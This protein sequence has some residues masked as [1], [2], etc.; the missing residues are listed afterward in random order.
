MKRIAPKGPVRARSSVKLPRR[1]N[2]PEVR[3]ARSGL[4][5]RG[6]AAPPAP[7]APREVEPARLRWEC[8]PKKISAKTSHQTLKTDIGTVGQER[9]IKALKMGISIGGPGYNIFVCGHQGT[10]R[11]SAVK[12]I[13]RAARPAWSKLRDRCYV[14]N[15]KDHDRP[16]L[17]TLE[18]GKGKLLKSEMDEAILLLKK[19]IP[20]ELEKDQFASRKKD[21][22]ERYQDNERELYGGLEDKLRKT[23]FCLGQVQEGAITRQ[24]LFP[25][26]DGKPYG[27]GQLE[28][29][30]GSG[31]LTL[32]E[33]RQYND[34]YTAFQPELAV[35]F[36]KRR[37]LAREMLREV[38]EME[39][40][41]V[42]PVMSGLLDDV[43]EKFAEA[44]V[45]QFLDEA[46]ESLVEELDLF[47]DDSDDG[48]EHGE[49]Q[50][51]G[52][53]PA[54]DARP[55]PDDDPFIRYRVNVILDNS[56]AT[57]PPVIV[58]TSPTF[59]NLFGT[60][61]KV[62]KGG[63]AHADFSGIRAGA[64]MRADGGFLILNSSDLLT[65]PHVWTTLKRAL[66]YRK[67]EIQ[68][69]ESVYQPVPVALKPEP[70]PLSLKVV[71]IGSPDTYQFL[72]DMDE[73]FNKIFKIKA[74]F[75]SEMRCNKE[76]LEH[77][78]R[79]VGKIA[80]EENLR[81]VNRDAM[82]TLAE[83]GV[84]RS[85]RQGKLTTHFSEIADILREADFLAGQQSDREITTRHLQQTIY[86]RQSRSNLLEGK[87]QEMIDEGILLI[88]TRGERVGAVN[89]LWVF[90][91]GSF[92]FGKPT[93]ITASTSPGKAGL[94]NVE[95]EVSLSGAAHD[96]G[97]L[98]I[99]GYLRHKYAHRVPLGLSASIC[100]EQSYSGVDGDSASLAEILA[101]I[102]DM[103]QVPIRQSIA[104][105]GSV[106]QKGEVQAVGGINEKIEGFYR[107]CKRRGLNGKQGVVIPEA[108]VEDLMLDDEVVEA[109]RRGKFHVFPVRTVDE[110]LF[111][112]TGKP[113]GARN[114]D[115]TFEPDT[116]N[117][118]V[119]QRLVEMATIMKD[120][121][122]L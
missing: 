74:E 112:V 108:N 26:I 23:G 41:A 98:I 95:R 57:V 47:K 119:Y 68:A 101:I 25:V 116:V 36:K 115:G 46:L 12:A 102:S 86:E 107:V 121:G 17:L 4:T 5:D 24:E 7:P 49:M 83:Y 6:T 11:T 69:P 20:L 64:L 122:G 39:R 92:A 15:F 54:P 3:A 65:E 109:A 34:A 103:S 50:E 59:T 27:M 62:E 60:L 13:L 45:A 44:E 33:V 111:T 18:P 66:R 67:L 73:D 71:M 55:R 100:F 19:N 114:A 70:M 52:A 80:K 96:K 72:S 51:G 118:R 79:V 78:F 61:E 76:N 40:E 106:N 28:E 1:P 2:P 87:L 90:E 53:E 77:F 22:I 48:A 110:A 84:R 88:D 99:G 32:E 104:I 85:G 10:G 91:L 8:D 37:L 97:V 56:E 42:R 30:I 58:E 82:A 9:A 113:A 63:A 81:T 93:R 75:D 43:R 105:T 117:D 35:L 16:R 120:Y 31:R 14:H 29:L 94:V 21:I 38:S 89:G